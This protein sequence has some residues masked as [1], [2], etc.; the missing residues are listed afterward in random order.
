MRFKA[1]LLVGRAIANM[2]PRQ[3]QGGALR[4][5][6]RRAQRRVDRRKIVAVRNRLDV[7][8]IGLKAECPILGEGNVGSGRQRHTVIVIEV[9]QLAELQMAG[10]LIYLYDDN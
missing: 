8:A 6:A 3:D 10:K 4:F 5:S 1:V 9:Y 2:G 7:P